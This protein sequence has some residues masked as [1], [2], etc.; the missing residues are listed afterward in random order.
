MMDYVQQDDGIPEEVQS[1]IG[2]IE[3]VCHESPCE[4]VINA[5]WLMFMREIMIAEEC[6]ALEAVEQVR[7]NLDKVIA[8]HS[9][10]H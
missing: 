10:R 9:P 8:I 4:D 3:T 2:E 6:S 1:L 5:L 7:N